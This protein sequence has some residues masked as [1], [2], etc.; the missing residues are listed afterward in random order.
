MPWPS[1]RDEEWMRTDIRT[2]DLNKFHF[3]GPPLTS[4]LPHAVLSAG[5]ELAGSAATCDGGSVS[6]P[7]LDRKW[8][9][10][11]VIFGNIVDLLAEHGELIQKYLFKNFDGKVDR[12]AALHQA[13]WATGTFLYVPR[14]VVID[15]PIHTLNTMSDGGTDFCHTLIVL[16]EGAEATVLAELTN[17]E[18]ETGLH[19]GA[20]EIFVG[21]RANLR[22]VN[23]Q[24]WSQR[25]WHFGHQKAVVGRDANLQWT[26]GRSARGWPRSINMWR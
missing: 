10:K 20:I 4:E 3:P 19:N 15:Q 21:D 2:F 14:N 5:V 11:G 1:T 6:A 18:G 16:E 23:L 22:Y 26:V 24:D 13:A 8:I 17:R 9:D 12:F 25:V 7:T